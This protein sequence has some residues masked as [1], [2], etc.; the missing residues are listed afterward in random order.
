MVFSIARIRTRVFRLHLRDA[1]PKLL[2]A[3]PVAFDTPLNPKPYCGCRFL[4]DR[5]WHGLPG[6]TTADSFALTFRPANCPLSSEFPVT[7]QELL[8]GRAS[9]PAAG[10]STG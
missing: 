9:N 10:Q 8:H 5:Y 4:G 3:P 7:C 6:R 2:W 1:S